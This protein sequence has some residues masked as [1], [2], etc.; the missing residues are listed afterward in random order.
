MNRCHCR[1]SLFLITTLFGQMLS[2]CSRCRAQ[3]CVRRLTVE[4]LALMEAS[5]FTI[6]TELMLDRSVG[7]RRPNQC[8]AYDCTNARESKKA[9]FCV[10]CRTLRARE[11]K[12]RYYDN[13]M[14]PARRRRRE[15]RPILSEQRRRGW[16]TRR[17]KVA[18]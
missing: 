18:A 13:E 7:P 11:C 9:R 15:N 3:A 5:P 14:K 10:E 17:T 12:R 8:T 16:A 1:G 6:V 2:E 4:Q